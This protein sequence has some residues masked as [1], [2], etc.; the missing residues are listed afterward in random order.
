MSGIKALAGETAIYGISSIVGRFL[1]W[2]LVPLYSYILVDTGDY[3]IVTNLYAWTSLIIIVLTYGMETGYFRFAESEPDSDRANRVYSTTLVTLAFTSILFA[4]GITFFSQSVAN[5]LK[6]PAHPEYIAMLGISVAMDAFGS[7][8]FSYLRFKRRPFTFA[9][10]KI[11]MILVNILF[12]IIFLVI[13]PKIHA[14]HPEWIDW[15][16]SPNYGA[17][18]IFVANLISTTVV[19]LALLP[20]VFNGAFHF[21]GALLKKMLRYSMPLLLFGIAGIMNQSIDKVIFPYIYPDQ[22]EGMQELGIYGSCFKIA[23]VMMMFTYAFRFAY[24]PFIFAKYKDADSRQTYA[25]VMKFFVIS[26]LAIYLFMLAFMDVFAML[27]AP[28]YRVGMKILP[29]VLITYLFQGIFYNLSL[30]YKLIDKTIYGT[31]FSLI[32]LTITVIINILLIP[33][34]SYMACVFASLVSL[35]IMMILS[36][37]LGQRHFRVPYNLKAIGKYCILAFALSFVMFL[38]S[39]DQLWQTLLWRSLLIIPFVVY[40]IYKDLPLS[41][42]SFLNRFTRKSK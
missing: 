26:S 13:C 39:F 1:N 28:Q 27:L 24:E 32:G 21:D 12:N 35:T 9:M 19:T 18:Y 15:F 16:Y 3:G 14:I 23:M 22:T 30:W 29:Y 20:F 34:F 42:F 7:I 38:L 36:Y 8:P 17:G 31:W 37:F 11:M 41:T 5:L 6:Y 4:T 40:V 33:R 2:L 10:L 25:E